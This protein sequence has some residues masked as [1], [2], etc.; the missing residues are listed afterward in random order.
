MSI[1]VMK[2][3][4]NESS[5][6]RESCKVLDRAKA[7]SSPPVGQPGEGP[8]GCDIPDVPWRTGEKEC[9]ASQDKKSVAVGRS[10]APGQIADHPIW[11]GRLQQI[12]GSGALKGKSCG[13][14]GQGRGHEGFVLHLKYNRK[15][16]RYLLREVMP[17]LCFGRTSMAAVEE[18]TGA[19]GAVERHPA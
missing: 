4:D 12:S 3:R 13:L 18:G 2:T 15:H 7:Q 9:S 8:I 19:Q 6:G 11:L 10:G 16:S 14:Y 5:A 17:G 1:S